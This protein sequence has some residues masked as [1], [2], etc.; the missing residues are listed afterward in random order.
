MELAQN[1]VQ[2]RSLVLAVLNRLAL[3]PECQLMKVVGVGGRWNWLRIV[4][5][6]GV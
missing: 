5:S 2:S 6:R 3:L 4:S 1:R